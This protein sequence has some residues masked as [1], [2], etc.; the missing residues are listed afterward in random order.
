[1]AGEFRLTGRQVARLEAAA[2]D[3]LAVLAELREPAPGW[4]YPVGDDEFPTADW[5]CACWHD[6]TGAKNDGYGH[7]G[8]DLNVDKA[9]WGDVDRGQPVI[10]VAPGVVHTVG[11]SASYLGG[12]VIEIEH[13]GAPLWVRYWHLEWV[14]QWQVGDTVAPGVCIGIIGDYKLGRGG[15]HCHLDMCRDPFEPHWWFTNHD[16]RWMDPVPI[17]KAHLDLATVDAMLAKKGR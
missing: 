5:Y 11:Y 12:V 14:T 9:P 15:D 2:A 7:T 8:I 4:T 6:P 10:A 13:E 17:L 1:M 3:V 16:L